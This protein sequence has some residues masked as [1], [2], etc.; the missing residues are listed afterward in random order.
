MTPNS[1]SLLVLISRAT[2][3]GSIL[4]A[5]VATNENGTI[6]MLA[7]VFYFYAHDLRGFEEVKITVTG[8]K[9]P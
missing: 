4:I 5:C 3:V 7:L 8:L 6:G 2:P 1:N 9:I